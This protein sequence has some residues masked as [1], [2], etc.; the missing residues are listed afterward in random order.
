MKILHIIDR[1]SWI[2]HDIAM[3]IAK[4][5]PEHKFGL[6]IG[7]KQGKDYYNKVKDEY[8]IHHFISWQFITM[9][10]IYPKNGVMSI[11]SWRNYYNKEVGFNIDEAKKRCKKVIANTPLL[12]KEHECEFIPDG[13]NLDLFSDEPFVV[14]FVG[15][16]DEYKGFKIV[17]DICRKN[18][19]K[20]MVA[21]G[22][23]HKSDMPSFYRKVNIVVQASLNE[24]F[25]AIV[26]ECLA[27]N[28][29]II[30]TAH[31]AHESVV[32]VA[33]DADAI[34]AEILKH[35]TRP[36]VIQYNWDTVIAKFKSLYE[37]L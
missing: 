4:R 7:H 29:P 20:L 31:G 11:C 12:A 10:D 15:R 9:W 33:R 21:D 28:V 25:N 2:F 27:M 13:I 23:L 32:E 22:D 37:T 34:E 1:P 17:E 16:R 36:K 6:C 24:G 19:L 14:G 5:L 8:D 26:A 35:Y 3:Q 18:N 30:T